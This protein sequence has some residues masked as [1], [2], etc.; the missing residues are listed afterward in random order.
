M[1]LSKNLFVLEAK[2]KET[3][4]GPGPGRCPIGLLIWP[5][6]LVETMLLISIFNTFLPFLNAMPTFPQ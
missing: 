2:F 6:K 4:Y 1:P 5:T 3:N